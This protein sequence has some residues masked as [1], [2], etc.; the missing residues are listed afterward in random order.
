MKIFPIKSMLVLALM[1]LVNAAQ[2]D[3]TAFG[4]TLS[5]STGG[6]V[7][8]LYKG[9]KIEEGGS[10][11]GG[12]IYDIPSDDVEF[13]GVKNLLVATDKDGVV[14]T[15][16]ALVSESKLDFLVSSLNKK[17]HVVKKELPRV[18]NKYVEYENDGDVIVLKAPHMSFDV[19]LG[20]HTKKAYQHL[21]ESRK[22]RAEDKKQQ[23][24][25]QL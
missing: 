7:Q 8:S 2:A 6:D 10:I 21:L 18:G 20:Y 1:F 12:R 4:I 16:F 3:T 22:K 17:Y 14:V 5:K 15:V 9:A 23:E 25:S 11:W 24:A 13:D 19:E